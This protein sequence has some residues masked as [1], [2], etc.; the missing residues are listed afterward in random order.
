MS[1]ISNIFKST[2]F[3]TTKELL[4]I[5]IALIPYAFAVNRIMVPHVIVAGGLTGLCEIIYFATNRFIPIWLSNLTIN[6]ILLV[7]AFRVVGWRFCLRTVYGAF[8]LSLWLKVIPIA[9]EPL[10]H[11]PFMAC[12]VSGVA[13]GMGLAVV[14]LNNGS[15][16]G[17]DIVAMIITKFRHVSIGSILLY[18]DLIIISSAY[19]LPDVRSVEKVLYGLC[20]TAVCSMTVDNVMNRLR[21]SVQFFIFSPKYDE[22]ANA[23][24]TRVNR[25]VTVLHGEGWYSKQPIHVLTVIAKK[26]ESERIF[27][28]VNEIDRNAFVSQSAVIGVFGKGFEPI[29]K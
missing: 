14:F 29:N 11:D 16:G 25:G 3:Q 26:S 28:L 20:F 23:I 12:I 7:I 2:Q 22:I 6:T 9:Q 17:T 4:F 8:F 10:M 13:C 15:S 19:F 24:N 5:A 21:Q 1:T 27:R 18:C